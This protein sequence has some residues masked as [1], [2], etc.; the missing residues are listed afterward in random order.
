MPTQQLSD[1]DQ[2]A[3]Y[4]SPHLKVL[5]ADS[6]HIRS[7]RSLSSTLFMRNFNRFSLQNNY[8]PP[9][10]VCHHSNSEGKKIYYIVYFEMMY[11]DS[12][13]GDRS[14]FFYIRA[15]V[16]LPIKQFMEL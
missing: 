16:S 6:N 3:K 14:N 5:I 9:S 10:E 1:L 15:K 8:I 2:V 11:I 4:D 13:G 7:I 12:L